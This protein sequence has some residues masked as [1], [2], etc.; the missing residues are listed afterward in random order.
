MK[1]KNI[2][3]AIIYIAVTHHLMS[4]LPAMQVTVPADHYPTNP[5]AEANLWPTPSQV[6]GLLYGG[7]E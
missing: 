1:I 4:C 2:I 7:M 6:Y 5:Q 3:I